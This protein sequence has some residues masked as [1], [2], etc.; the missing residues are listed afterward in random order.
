[1]I[2]ANRMRHPDIQWE[3]WDA[4]VLLDKLLEPPM[5]RQCRQHRMADGQAL[6]LADRFDAGYFDAIV[7]KTLIDCFLTRTGLRV[8][9]LRM[10]L[11]MLYDSLSPQ[12]ISS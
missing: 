3:C 4:L 7:G 1:M 8:A 11:C 5:G 10:E 12:D 6:Q 9:Y 2:N